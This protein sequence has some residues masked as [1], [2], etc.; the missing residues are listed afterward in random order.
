[1]FVVE[2]G[3]KIIAVDSD[4]VKRSTPVLDISGR[5]LS[6]GEL[7][8]LGFAL[9]PNGG[10]GKNHF[11]VNYTRRVQSPNCLRGAAET[12]IARYQFA[13]A[14]RD[15]ADAASEQ[16]LMTICQPQSNHN[17]GQ[18]VF[19]P[20]GLLY[21][22]MGD[23]GSGDDPPNN[24]Q[25]PTTPLGKML[26]I[27]VESGASPYA[28]P[29][30]N[31]NAGNALCNAPSQQRGAACP[32][33]WASGLRNPWRFSFDDAGNLYIGDVGQNAIEEI[34]FVASG[35]LGQGGKNFGWRVFEGNV[36]HIPNSGGNCVVLPSHA[37]PIFTY[38]HTAAR[39]SI[40]G[41]FAY[42]GSA[43][44]DLRGFYLYGDLCSGEIFALSPAAPAATNAAVARGSGGPLVSFGEDDANELLVVELGGSLSRL[45][46]RP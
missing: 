12:V 30:G 27:D 39:C 7:G 43:I 5:V 15:V 25:N 26:R 29:G 21:I 10:A 41:G 11:Y 8:L 17:G 1:M 14:S 46:R 23:G 24:A 37:A 22:G 40:T 9:P 32:E 20:D 4:G 13:S 45:V 35:E 28:V 34:D 42:R 44:A 18:I 2:Q 19:G 6:G 33:I 31:P 16:V 3:G 38:Q 36:C